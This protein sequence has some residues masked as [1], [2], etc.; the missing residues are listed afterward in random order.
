MDSGPEMEK[1]DSSMTQKSREF[2]G[3]IITYT[4]M[5]FVFAMMA[6]SLVD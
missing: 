6:W 1:G 4:F 2:I 3:S 5:M